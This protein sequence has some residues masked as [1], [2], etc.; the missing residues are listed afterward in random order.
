MDAA[1]WIRATPRC[2]GS[3]LLTFPAPRP[4]APT[5]LQLSCSS[6]AAPRYRFP[7]MVDHGRVPAPAVER[8]IF[9]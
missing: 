4:P 6:S 8:K 5:R 2:V 3:G 1:F 7:G 9:P